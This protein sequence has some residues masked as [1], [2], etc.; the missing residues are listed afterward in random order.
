MTVLKENPFLSEKKMFG[1]WGIYLFQTKYMKKG[2]LGKKLKVYGRNNL[3]RSIKAKH[4]QNKAWKYHPAAAG[5]V[6]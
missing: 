6:T 4:T 1:N 2:Y 5:P 3:I